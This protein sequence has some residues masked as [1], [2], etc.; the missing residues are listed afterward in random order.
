M[1]DD[2]AVKLDV[3]AESRF[4]YAAGLTGILAMISVALFLGGNLGSAVE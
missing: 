2:T 1:F 3:N 4:A